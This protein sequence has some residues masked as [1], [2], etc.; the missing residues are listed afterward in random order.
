MVPD[1]Q[2]IGCLPPVVPPVPL[3]IPFMA[4]ARQVSTLL[5]RLIYG[6]NCQVRHRFCP[7]V[8]QYPDIHLPRPG[9]PVDSH[10]GPTHWRP[11]H[12]VHIWIQRRQN[13]FSLNR[14]L[15]MIDLSCGPACK[16][17]RSLNSRFSAGFSSEITLSFFMVV[18]SFVVCLLRRKQFY[19]IRGTAFLFNLY[20]R[21]GA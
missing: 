16:L 1:R 7:W 4:R 21:N 10:Y 8:L 9:A 18:F 14:F 20:T 15:A 11:F 19:N 6:G 2:A 12:T 3:I 5:A 17:S 13:S